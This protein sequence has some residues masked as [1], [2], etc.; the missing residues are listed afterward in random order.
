MFCYFL[1]FIYFIVDKNCW[2][3]WHNC[4]PL[5]QIEAVKNDVFCQSMKHIHWNKICNTL[6]LLQN[7]ILMIAA[8]HRLWKFKK[9]QIFLG[10]DLGP[11]DRRW[12]YIRCSYIKQILS[13]WA[14]NSRVDCTTKKCYFILEY[15]PAP[16]SPIHF[17]FF[18]CTH[19]KFE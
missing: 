3:L 7:H 12:A 17:V 8:V 18:K 1:S 19:S 16:V 13:Q 11:R 6:Y 4:G 9:T 14:Y 10:T 15:S 5:W 2:N